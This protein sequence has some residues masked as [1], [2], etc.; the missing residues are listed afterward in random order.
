MSEVFVWMRVI[1]HLWSISPAVIWLS[2]R[3]DDVI[4]SSH[5]RNDCIVPSLR[6]LTDSSAEEES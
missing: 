5:L 2:S 1:D 6:S 4:Y 3:H